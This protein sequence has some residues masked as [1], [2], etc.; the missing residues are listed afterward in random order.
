MQGVVSQ[1][2][3]EEGRLIVPARIDWASDRMNLFIGHECMKRPVRQAGFSIAL[4]RRCR[5]ECSRHKC[6]RRPKTRLMAHGEEVREQILR[7]TA[8]GRNALAF[9]GKCARCR[10]A[11][12][13]PAAL[14]K[15]PNVERS[16]TLRS[17]SSRLPSTSLTSGRVTVRRSDRSLHKRRSLSLTPGCRAARSVL[18]CWYEHG[19]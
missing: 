9:A 18:H 3:A 12:R 19:R 14:S 13:E 6:A 2:V 7:G 4:A 1:S 16:V 15:T 5:T 8:E 17:L 10:N 11:E